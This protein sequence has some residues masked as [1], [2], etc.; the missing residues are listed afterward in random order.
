LESLNRQYLNLVSEEVGI[1]VERG[2]LKMGE[3]VLT[4]KTYGP[5]IYIELGRIHRAQKRLM[6]LSYLN[7]VERMRLTV[8]LV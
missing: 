5:L 8:H 7:V 4:T 3:L 1:N 2:F 6:N